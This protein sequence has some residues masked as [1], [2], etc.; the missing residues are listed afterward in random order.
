LDAVTFFHPDRN[1]DT[2]SYKAL[3][4]VWRGDR[5]RIAAYRLE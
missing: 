1:P 4:I 5:I 3:Q 2:R